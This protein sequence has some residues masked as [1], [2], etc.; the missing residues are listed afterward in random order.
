MV[1]SYRVYDFFSSL[2]R[3]FLGGPCVFFSFLESLNEITARHFCVP[4]D[5]LAGVESVFTLYTLM[6]VRNFLP[7]FL[8]PVSQIDVKVI[9]EL[10]IAKQFLEFRVTS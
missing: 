6:C 3:R 9:L 7:L 10:S 8:V 5:V 2:S 4:V 1:M